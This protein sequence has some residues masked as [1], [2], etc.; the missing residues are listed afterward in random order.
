MIK[1]KSKSF[2]KTI[3]DKVRYKYMIQ[4]VKCFEIKIIAT[5]FLK[6]S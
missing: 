3:Y 5:F 2:L 6:T 1:N 4:N